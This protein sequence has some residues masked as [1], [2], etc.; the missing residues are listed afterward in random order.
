MAKARG[1]KSKVSRSKVTKSTKKSVNRLAKKAA[2]LKKPTKKK[3]AK[4]YMRQEAKQLPQHAAPQEIITQPPLISEEKLIRGP[5][6]KQQMEATL[7]KVLPTNNDN[8]TLAVRSIVAYA[9]KNNLSIEFVGEAGKKVPAIALPVNQE[10]KSVDDATVQKVTKLLNGLHVEN[11][12]NPTIKEEG[13]D[14]S[15][16]HPLTPE[17]KAIARVKQDN[18]IEITGMMSDDQIAALK[19]NTESKY[20]PP[21]GEQQPAAAAGTTQKQTP[22]ERELTPEE[23]LGRVLSGRD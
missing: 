15:V 18:H 1:K 4:K 7:Q 23:K 3:A 13:Y 21:V 8:A 16:L 9:T 12:G 22:K 11:S 2:K 10:T 6:H 14:S 17:Q 20:N 5:G 19:S